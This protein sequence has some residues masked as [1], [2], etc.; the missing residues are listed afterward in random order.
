MDRYFPHDEPTLPTASTAK[1][2]AAQMQG[3]YWSS[4]RV[5]G[6]YLRMLNLLGQLKVAA[7]K[8][9]TLTVSALK[10]DAG[11]PLVWREVGPYVWKDASG[12]HTLAAVVKDGK[13]VQFGADDLAAI[14]LFQPTPFASSSS[15]NLPLLMG[16]VGVLAATLLLWPVQVLVR[17]RYGQRFALS[18]RTAM[19]YRAVRVTALIDLLALGGFF[20]V[21]Q[22]TSTNLALFDDPLDL[23]L[24]VL[25]LL[26]LLGVVGAGL[27]VWNAFRVWTEGGRSWW[28][29]ASVTVTTLALLAFVWFV[30]SLQLVTPS[31]NY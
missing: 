31:L 6:G 5:E 27:A 17:R 1:A 23:W 26:C 28:A 2:H 3:V 16:M 14:M 19:L 13:V 29:K 22:A 7:N 10:D 9:G 24:R 25:Q 21:A 20:A 11:Q 12:K 15:W 8:D 4:R 30:V 18:G